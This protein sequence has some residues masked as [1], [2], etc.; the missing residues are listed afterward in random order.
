[1]RFGE[2]VMQLLEERGMTQIELARRSGL[3][4]PH[5]NRII[6]GG[7]EYPSI[8]NAFAT[9]AVRSLDPKTAQ[10]IMGHSNINMT[11]KYADTEESQV[12]DA[13]R[14]LPF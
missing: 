1:M 7:I 13:S 10:S 2:L 4:R 8:E 14:L 3:S 9:V 11:M 12:R 5:I 6:K